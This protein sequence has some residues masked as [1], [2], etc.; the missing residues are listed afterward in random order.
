M[1]CIVSTSK[2]RNLSWSGKDLEFYAYLIKTGKFKI[3]QINLYNINGDDR[4][5]LHHWPMQTKTFCWKQHHHRTDLKKYP[6][7]WI[8]RWDSASILHLSKLDVIHANWYLYIIIIIHISIQFNMETE[9]SNNFF[10]YLS[11]QP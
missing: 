4:V 8:I 9:N 5:I 3:N 6:H 1:F 10:T 11:T 7:Q 2:I